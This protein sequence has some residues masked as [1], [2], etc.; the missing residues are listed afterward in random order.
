ML[1]RAEQYR[2]QLR[3]HRVGGG[4]CFPAS[5]LTVLNTWDSDFFLEVTA[6]AQLLLLRYRG[7]EKAA[8]KAAKARGDED[9]RGETGGED[10][11]TLPPPIGVAE[12]RA[13]GDRP[14]QCV[15][16]RPIED[17]ARCVPR[18]GHLPGLQFEWRGG[19]KKMVVLLA[20]EDMDECL[21]VVGGLLRQHN[22]ARMA[23]VRRLGVLQQ[24]RG[25]PYDRSH[26]AHEKEL[27]A[28]WTTTFPDTELPARKC[29]EWGRLGFQ[30]SD[31][32]T[33]FRAMGLLG[34]R[35]LLFALREHQG[36]FAA[37]LA[38]DKEYPWAITGINLASTLLD[39]VGMKT[40]TAHE[41][42]TSAAWNS[43]A[44]AFLCRCHAAGSLFAYEDLFAR[45]L[46]YFDWFW[47]T[48]GARYMDFPFVLK[49]WKEDIVELLDARPMTLGAL[50]EAISKQKSSEDFIRRT[51][52]WRDREKRGEFR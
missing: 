40:A 25:T 28:L 35:V 2:E 36:A 33:D 9:G 26:A 3:Q 31:P 13:W 24:W 34:L 27:L 29:T 20:E 44:F 12:E 11:G 18:P 10:D 1:S 17:V 37:I 49:A 41:P 51:Q 5:V 47:D 22:R 14:L 30:G 45:L 46:L 52:S 8:A 32:A 19:G 42:A 38:E 50:D 39:M 21:E 23:V 48:M 6:D 43:S 4:D 7:S 15:R 16:V